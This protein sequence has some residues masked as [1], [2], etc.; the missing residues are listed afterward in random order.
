MNIELEHMDLD[1]L[2]QLYE[3]VE[4]MLTKRRK[5]QELYDKLRSLLQKVEQNGYYLVLDNGY[6]GE[7]LTYA[8]ARGQ[9]E[10]REQE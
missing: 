8:F 9:I 6:E 5:Q 1:E 2:R 7:N 10:L 3:D 4:R